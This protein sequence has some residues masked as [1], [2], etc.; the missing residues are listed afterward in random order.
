[1]GSFT[2]SE[3]CRLNPWAQSREKIGQLLCRCSGWEGKRL[4]SLVS[5]LSQSEPYFLLSSPRILRVLCPRLHTSSR[6][7]HP[8][9]ES[10][11][12][13]GQQ[14]R[15]AEHKLLL[16]GGAQERSKMWEVGKTKE[17]EVLSHHSHCDWLGG[18]PV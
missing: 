14:L 10:E 4:G 2:L 6:C 3:L 16:K 13:P 8:H 11:L 17:K 5:C 1:M 15:K 18:S 12:T 7:Q 9:R